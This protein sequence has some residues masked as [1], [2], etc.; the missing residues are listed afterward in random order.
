MSV[1][2]RTDLRNYE[3]AIMCQRET[4]QY[5]S[6]STNHF[7]LLCCVFAANIRWYLIKCSKSSI[8]SD[9]VTNMNSLGEHL[10]EC[11]KQLGLSQKA[12]TEKTGI[13]DSRLSRIENG[14][15]DC[16]EIFACSPKHM[17]CRLFLCFWKPA[18]LFL[19][20]LMNTSMYSGE[21]ISW[22]M[23]TVNIF[24]MRLIIW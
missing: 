21:L 4:E 20:T 11:R 6:T 24:K 8:L 5:Y 9:E 23:K 16:P 13:T 15:L 1:I 18:I 3:I 19:K 12:V 17:V 14:Q 7:L 22:M 2:L 10:K